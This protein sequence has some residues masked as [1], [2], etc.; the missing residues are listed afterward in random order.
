M[1]GA[2]AQRSGN[3]C[4]NERQGGARGQS[5]KSIFLAD[6]PKANRRAEQNNNDGIGQGRNAICRN[7]QRSE[8]ARPECVQLLAPDKALTPRFPER[9]GRPFR[10][11]LSDGPLFKLRPEN[12]SWLPLAWH[13]LRPDLTAAGSLADGSLTNLSTDVESVL[14]PPVTGAKK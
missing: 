5:P 3:P 9:Q 4:A 7:P 13:K 14:L 10:E 8:S 2:T 11:G 1:P 12:Q 6:E